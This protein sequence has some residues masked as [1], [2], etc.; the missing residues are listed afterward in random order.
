MCIQ[1]CCKNCQDKLTVLTHHWARERCNDYYIARSEDRTTTDCPRGPWV[2]R[3]AYHRNPYKGVQRC[4][5]CIRAG[6]KDSKR[7][8]LARQKTN[9]AH[10][11]RREY[12]GALYVGELVIPEGFHDTPQPLVRSG[13]GRELRMAPAETNYRSPYQPVQHPPMQNI[14]EGKPSVGCEESHNIYPYHK[15]SPNDRHPITLAKNPYSNSYTTNQNP[16]TTVREQTS[17]ETHR[18]AREQLNLPLRASS[19]RST[20]GRPW[21]L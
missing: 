17:E 4:D 12:A 18:G 6:R 19:S 9:M 13:E 16:D 15:T 20:R 21:D 7:V 10:G 2:L 14:Y 1:W 5:D 3:R 8:Q 11:D